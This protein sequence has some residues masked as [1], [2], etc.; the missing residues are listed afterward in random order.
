MKRLLIFCVWIA[1]CGTAEADDWQRIDQE[2]IEMKLNNMQTQLL[3]MEIRQGT[4]ERTLS[5]LQTQLSTMEMR[6]GMNTGIQKQTQQMRQQIQLIQDQ[7]QQI[8][9]EIAKGGERR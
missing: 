8:Q 6:Q 9:R 4:V 7:L 2:I 1:L 3:T 5:D